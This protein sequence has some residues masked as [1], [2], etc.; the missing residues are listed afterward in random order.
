M[1]GKTFG[2][3]SNNSRPYALIAVDEPLYTERS[4][5]S[6]RSNQLMLLGFNLYRELLQRSELNYKGCQS[7]PAVN[8]GN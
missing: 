2:K 6:R 5:L 3:L 1:S 4:F 8:Q 7:Q